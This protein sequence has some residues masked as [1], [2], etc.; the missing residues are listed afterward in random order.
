MDNTCEDVFVVIL[1]STDCPVVILVD[2]DMH[3]QKHSAI[4]KNNKARGSALAQA[5]PLA[6]QLADPCA[7]GRLASRTSTH[8]AAKTLAALRTHATFLL[9][10]VSTV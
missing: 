4:R 8:S 9:V 2:S 5:P 1:G 3:H 7:T 6:A 10:C